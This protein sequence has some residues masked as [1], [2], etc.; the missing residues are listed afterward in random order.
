M[1]AMSHEFDLSLATVLSPADKPGMRTDRLTALTA[2]WEAVHEAAAAVGILAQLG[3]EEESEEIRSL[4]QRAL[5]LGGL[6]L[7]SVA[8]GVDDLAAVMQPGLRALLSLT[9]TG[10]DTTSA[11]LTL[12]REFHCARAAILALAPPE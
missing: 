4:P 2:Q 12:W 5:E 9:A 11:A 8:R 6:N 7:E 3:E 10:H 1:S